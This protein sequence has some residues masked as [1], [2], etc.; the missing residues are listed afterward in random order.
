VTAA[1]RGD[2][3]A[4]LAIAS[5]SVA[6][7]RRLLAQ[8][9]R[10]HGL[11]SANLDARLLVGHAL[12]LDHAALVTQAE[13]ALTSAEADAVAAILAR[14]LAREPVARIVGT[15]EFWGLA[16][17]LNADT[18]VPRPETETV[19]EAALAALDRRGSRNRPLRVADLGTGSGA[20]LLALLSELPGAHGV[21]TDVS[22]EN[23]RAHGMAE[24]AAFVACDF[25]TALHGPFDLVV[26]NPPYVRHG[27]IAALDPEVRLFDPGRA[28]DGGPDGLDAYRAIARDARRLASPGGT[29][30]LELGAGA[31]AAV[32]AL[33]ADAGLQDIQSRDDLAGTPRALLAQAPPRSATRD[34]KR[35]APERAP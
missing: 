17:A 14:R 28:L 7:A 13:R 11:D 5:L 35:G 26:S 25:G 20:L 2:A 22:P 16:L 34:A 23:A 3:P 24:R 8:S 33:L 12:G 32:T 21:G 6:G 4:A 29:L 15:K 30:V 9:F 27:D 10:A 18:L 31:L 19:V 1:A